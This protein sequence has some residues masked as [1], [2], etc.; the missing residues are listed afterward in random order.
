MK[1]GVHP[2]NESFMTQTACL[3]NQYL[4]KDISSCSALRKYQSTCLFLII[5]LGNKFI[6]KTS[7]SSASR[8]LWEHYVPIKGFKM[9]PHDT[10]GVPLFGN[11]TDLDKKCF[12]FDKIAQQTSL[13]YS[14]CGSWKGPL[15]DFLSNFILSR[16]IVFVTEKNSMSVMWH[17][18][19]QIVVVFQL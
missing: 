3:M 5:S 1:Y 12:T 16:S 11:L 6:Q 7:I 19:I 15:D 8:N 17:N 9:S 14:N 4:N 18:V 13:H 10:F 2:Q